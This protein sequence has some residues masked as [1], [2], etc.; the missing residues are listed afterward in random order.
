MGAKY[1]DSAGVWRDAVGVKI[2]AGSTYTDSAGV[3]RDT[4]GIKVSAD[5]STG[6]LGVT[7]ET[8]V[9]T[10]L[11]GFNRDPIGVKEVA[12][13]Y[14]DAGGQLR[15]P[16]PIF[17]VSGGV[18]V[19]QP[20]RVVQ[21]PA[22][23]PKGLNGAA[24]GANRAT[25]TR[26]PFYIGSG[27]AD[28]LVVS[29]VNAYGS[30]LTGVNR[31]I[32]S[33]CIEKDGGARVQVLKAGVAT[34][35]LP[36]GT[37]DY[38][39]DP[40]YP[41][42][43]GQTK[44]TQGDLYW[45]SVDESVPLTTDKIISSYSPISQ[46][47]GQQ[48][49]CYDPTVVTPPVLAGGTGAFVT[50]G[51]TANSN[52]VP[53]VIILGRHQSAVRTW[54]G[55][56]ASFFRDGVGS[57]SASFRSQLNLYSGMFES[58]LVNQDKT[59]WM[60]GAT[61]PNDSSDVW[62]GINFGVF[63]TGNTPY[64]PSTDN[65]VPYF[66]YL[67]D[68]WESFGG[69]DSA[70]L[71]ADIQTAF[72]A[73][74]TKV[75]SEGVAR[76]WRNE[77][78]TRTSSTDGW[79]TDL[80]QTYAVGY[81]PGST[82]E[83][84]DN[85]FHTQVGGLLYAVMAY[86]RGI[87]SPTDRWKF[88]TNYGENQ[89][90]WVVSD[91]VHFTTNVMYCVVDQVKQQVAT[92]TASVPS[93]VSGVAVRAS[94][95]HISATWDTN[96]LTNGHLFEYKATASGTWIPVYTNDYVGAAQVSGLTPSTSYDYRIT[97]INYRGT[98][99]PVTGTIS[100]VATPTLLIDGLTVG[101]SAMSY[102]RSTIRYRGAYL[103]PVLRVRRDRDG[104]GMDVY[105]VPP[106]G[107][108]TEWAIDEAYL[109]KWLGS[110]GYARIK[111]P[112]DQSGNR[113][114]IQGS[115]TSS[116]VTTWPPLVIAGTPY[117]QKGR[118]TW[119]YAADAT[120]ALTAQSTQTGVGALPPNPTFRTLIAACKF[121]TVNANHAVV[122]GGTSAYQFGSTSAA[123]YAITRVGGSGLITSTSSLV[124]N[125]PYVLSAE[126]AVGAQALFNNGVAD[127]TAASATTFASANTFIYEGVGTSASPV[128]QGFTPAIADYDNASAIL[129]TADRQAIEAKF[130]A[131]WN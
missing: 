20:L 102:V 107:S 6:A 38:Q 30:T 104:M 91:N 32:N 121:D 33:I 65:R 77:L 26:Y 122:G 88:A 22:R 48:S 129:P 12:G 103:G 80:N 61:A 28:S 9:Y 89:V 96:G 43:F 27:D 24:A 127:G 53:G 100:T 23:F 98:G 5:A 108:E 110:A 62:A 72:I 59:S 1:Q 41:A 82:M 68:V 128:H 111:R 76:I 52:G 56:G 49:Y 40:V 109:L 126:Y 95:T 78:P 42:A 4:I 21:S 10:D 131:D 86:S 39:Y 13:P 37:I 57:T 92:L 112:Y 64:N 81:G 51:L 106:S 116:A 125:T 130:I 19:E 97:P 46:F 44:F 45:W 66:K 55:L 99:T 2:V 101:G 114:D 113:N 31:V 87:R 115:F 120:R 79:L 73:L 8:G 117:R 85:W 54:G 18:P 11:G 47:I 84:V 60:N 118:I 69:N 93:A 7:V 119:Y 36:Y 17:Y 124:A 35:N 94:D 71:L 16:L 14:T 70:E 29:L 25:I 63:G 74:W 15:D 83:A 90:N 123:K 58:I 75:K 34:A 105:A 67:T 3:L 50:T